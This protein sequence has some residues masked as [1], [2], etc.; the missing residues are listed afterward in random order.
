MTDASPKSR[1]GSENRQRCVLVGFRALP[2]EVAA[3][4]AAADRVGLTR[5]SYGRACMLSPPQMRATRRPPV[6]QVALAKLLGDIGKIGSNVNQIARQLNS[7]RN[8]EE[9]ADI[10]AT[11]RAI[12]EMR[13]AVLLALGM[14]ADTD[15]RPA[16]VR[17]R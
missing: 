13:D 17:R 12:W 8:P 9:V 15:T 7:G 1:S 5:S 10:A 3:I 11:L 4:D 14:K 16:T 2:S 6:N